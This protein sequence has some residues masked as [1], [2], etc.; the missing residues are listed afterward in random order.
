MVIRKMPAGVDWEIC[1]DGNPHEFGGLYPMPYPRMGLEQ[2]C[3]KCGLIKGMD[4]SD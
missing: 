2:A 3:K 1:S 4:S